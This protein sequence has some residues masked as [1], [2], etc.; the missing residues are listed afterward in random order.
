VV[1][2]KINLPAG[3]YGLTGPDGSKTRRVKPG[4]SVTVTDE[5]ARVINHSSNASLG[6]ISGTQAAVIGTKRGRWCPACARLWQ[7]W[8]VTCPRCGRDTEEEE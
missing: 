2:P 8:S 6:I 7:A 1:V 3:C 4:T 5:Q